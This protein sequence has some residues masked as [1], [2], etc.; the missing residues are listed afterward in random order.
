MCSTR[1][2]GP[3]ALRVKRSKMQTI[4]CPLDHTVLRLTHVDG[5]ANMCRELSSPMWWFLILP[6][7]A[8]RIRRDDFFLH[9]VI[10]SCFSCVSIAGRYMCG[11]C[12]WTDLVFISRRSVFLKG[13][14][15]RPLKCIFEHDKRRFRASSPSASLDA[16]PRP[17]PRAVHAQCPPSPPRH[18]FCPSPSA[19]VIFCSPAP[20]LVTLSH[21][22]KT[23][24]L[25]RH[26]NRAFFPLSFRVG[27]SQAQSR[28]SSGALPRS[29][30]M[31]CSRDEKNLVGGEH[32]FFLM[33]CCGRKFWQC[34]RVVCFK[35]DTCVQNAHLEV[36]RYP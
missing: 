36:T 3:V 28:G 23:M 7:V 22:T 17:L 4:L 14:Q 16:C 24:F 2:R 18:L 26:C 6:R 13:L 33:Q 10:M 9:I 31:K 21:A 15:Q 8:R 27:P 1:C 20:P 25:L 35:N 32:S 29:G 34:R 12:G 11:S 19:F 5:E 30:Y